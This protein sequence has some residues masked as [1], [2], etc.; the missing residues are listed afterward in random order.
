MVGEPLRYP[1]GASPVVHAVVITLLPGEETARHRHG[2]PLFAYVL[3][4][5]LTVDYAGHGKRIYRK[6]GALLEAMDVQHVGRN[7]GAGPVRILAVF[8]GA[9]G[10]VETMSGAGAPR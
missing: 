9:A 4:G 8:L 1:G 5:E 3:E 6:G 7:T 10:K 2:V